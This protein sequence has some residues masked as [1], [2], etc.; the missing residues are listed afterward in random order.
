MYWI[1]KCEKVHMQVSRVYKT[2]LNKTPAQEG[3]GKVNTKM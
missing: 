2:L 3:V 1:V